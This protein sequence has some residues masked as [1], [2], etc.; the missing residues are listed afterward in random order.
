MAF[1]RDERFRNFGIPVNK[2]SRGLSRGVETIFR[3]AVINSDALRNWSER[4]VLL[5]IQSKHPDYSL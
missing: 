2:V 4:F 5:S 3:V 1:I